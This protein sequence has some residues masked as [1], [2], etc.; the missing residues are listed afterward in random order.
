VYVDNY[1]NGHTDW[2]FTVPSLTRASL[3]YD[4]NT[5]FCPDPRAGARLYEK[6]AA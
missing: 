2:T 3:A 1:R 6:A 5:I 4:G